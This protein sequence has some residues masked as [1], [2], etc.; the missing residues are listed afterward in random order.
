MDEADVRRFV[1]LIDMSK[2]IELHVDARTA[3]G[4]RDAILYE[5]GM[6]MSEELF[7]RLHAV[8][9]AHRA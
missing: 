8:S 7:R 1:A 9:C 3:A 4:V 2:P 6:R 5:G